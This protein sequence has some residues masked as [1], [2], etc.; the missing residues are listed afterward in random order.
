MQFVR[1]RNP[2]EEDRVI[3]LSQQF[4]ISD[5]RPTPRSGLGFNIPQAANSMFYPSA[6]SSVN[7]TSS[8]ANGAAAALSN[9]LSAGISSVGNAI[10]AGIAGKYHLQA[11]NDKIDW[12]KEQWK[13][14][15]DTAKAMGLYSPAQ[16]G[17][18][19]T[20][21]PSSADVYRLNSRGLVRQPRVMPGSAFGI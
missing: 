21:A 17:A 14:N 10:T 12:E 9:P 18:A 5:G 4:P 2:N 16:I 8:L 19:T 15:W 6:N 1:A 11:I 20:G 7:Q 3:P 13:K